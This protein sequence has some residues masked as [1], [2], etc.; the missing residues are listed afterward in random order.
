MTDVPYLFS[1][2]RGCRH[3]SIKGKT[4]PDEM[5][6][7]ISIGGS[8]TRPDQLGLTLERLSSDTLSVTASLG[9]QR[10]FDLSHLRNVPGAPAL[11]DTLDRSPLGMASI[12]S[13]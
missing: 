6:M 10:P 3:A 13:P 1:T 8:I 12:G 9:G 7:T 2:F 5:V 11:S 4:V